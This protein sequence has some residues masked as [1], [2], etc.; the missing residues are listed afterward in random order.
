MERF[1]LV[2]CHSLCS[3]QFTKCV[4]IFAS[5]HRSSGQKDTQETQISIYEK[6]DAVDK[7]AETT[8]VTV[9]DHGFMS[10]EESIKTLSVESMN[11]ITTCNDTVDQVGVRYSDRG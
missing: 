1:A 11:V 3:F 7:E 6:G 8:E 2:V 10:S 9:E 4:H 5:C